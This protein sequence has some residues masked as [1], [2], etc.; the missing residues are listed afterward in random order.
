MPAQLINFA[1][2]IQLGGKRLRTLRGGA[3]K[4]PNFEETLN[5]SIQNN[6][7]AIALFYADWC[8]H[9]KNFK[10]TWLGLCNMATKK[11]KLI[12][13]NDEKLHEKYDI[14]S[15]PTIRLYV[16]GKTIEYKGSRDMDALID[17]INAVVGFNAFKKLS[18]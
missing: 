4:Q 11:I 5:D 12:Q 14:N 2:A 16:N 1:K 3:A 7:P 10:P 8:G 6:I 15:Y 17:Y 18:V 13:T 9:C